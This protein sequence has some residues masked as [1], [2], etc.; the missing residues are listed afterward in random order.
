MQNLSR[1]AE[2]FEDNIPLMPIRAPQT[3][4]EMIEYKMYDRKMNQKELAVLLGVSQTRL[5]EVI[6]GKR[7]VNLDLAKRLFT[8]LNIDPA[9][10]LKTA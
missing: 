7:K 6:Q 2:A 8:N 3:L 5:S 4:V 9:F 10:I 1:M